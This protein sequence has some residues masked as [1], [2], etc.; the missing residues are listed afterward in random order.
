MSKN[1]LVPAGIHPTPNVV[2]S[3]N[4]NLAHKM[5]GSECPVAFQEILGFQYTQNGFSTKSACLKL[6]VRPYV[7]TKTFG[8]KSIRN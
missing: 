1:R 7:R 5:L 3:L 6:F 4:I 2:F 8:N